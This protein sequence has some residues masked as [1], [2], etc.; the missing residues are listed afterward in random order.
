MNKFDCPT[1]VKF[2][3]GDSWCHGIAHNDCIICSC[4][5]GVFEIAAIIEIAKEAEIENPIQILEWADFTSVIQE[6]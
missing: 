2:F 5:G 6:E 3:D 1:Q 4:C